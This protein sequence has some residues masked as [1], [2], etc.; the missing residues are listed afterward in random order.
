MG[1]RFLINKEIQN[2]VSNVTDSPFFREN[3]ISQLK[4]VYLNPRIL[5]KLIRALKEKHDESLI[6]PGENVGI[7]CA[8]SIGE[9]FTQSTLNTFHKAGLLISGATKGIP[10][11][12]ELLNISKNP[13]SIFY[14]YV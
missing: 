5:P 3:Y 14:L 1:K 9:K 10:R 7:I 13:K 4:T 6:K 2:I 12:Q 8:Q 11:V